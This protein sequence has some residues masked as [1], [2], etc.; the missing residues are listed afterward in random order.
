MSMNEF[1]E[2]EKS[3]L[4]KL[5]DDAIRAHKKLIETYTWEDEIF[6]KIQKDKIA[7]IYKAKKALGLY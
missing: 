5:F 3:E 4:N 6:R 2:Q 7:T 1:N